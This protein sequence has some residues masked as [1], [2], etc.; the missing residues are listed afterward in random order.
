MRA[1]PLTSV[2]NDGV[3]LLVLSPHLDDAILSCGALLAYAGQRV[4]VT[5]A[6]FFTEGAPPPYTLSARQFLRQVGIADAMQLYD[7]RRAEDRTV[8]EGMGIAWR[9]AG[10]TDALFRRKARMPLGGRWPARRLPAELVHV[11][12]TYRLHIASGRLAVDDDDTL[13]RAIA[14]AQTLVAERSSLVLAPLG[15]GGHV[16]H[17]LVRTA[18][19]LCSG[20]RVIYYSELPYNQRHALD[21]AFARRTRFVRTTWSLELAAKAALIRGYRTQV[22]A[23]FPNGRIPVVPEVYLLPD[24][25]VAHDGRAQARES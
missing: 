17:I 24:I 18:A 10:L 23:L 8:L 16:D 1:D 2:I 20:G 4:P 12:P 15:I 6:T 19:A 3:P 22:D 21:A 7:A 9:H 14:F 11:Y 25:S 13:G 5:V